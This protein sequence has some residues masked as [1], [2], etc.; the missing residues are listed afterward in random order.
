MFTSWP[1]AM[2]ELRPP[3]QSHSPVGNE[4]DPVSC[5][6][7]KQP[8]AKKKLNTYVNEYGVLERTNCD[9]LSES[10]YEYESDNSDIDATYIPDSSSDGE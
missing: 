2:L 5:A 6:T 4:T 10:E 1:D 8:I 3:K 7:S 9:P